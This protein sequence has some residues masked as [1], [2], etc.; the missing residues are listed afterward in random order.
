MS[1]NGSTATDVSGA[2]DR[3]TSEDC[4]GSRSVESHVLSARAKIR[5]T[6]STAAA[7]ASAGFRQRDDALPA[8][9]VEGA[10][11]AIWLACPLRT[12]SMSAG[13]I[14]LTGPPEASSQ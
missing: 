8:M 9:T 7:E 4:C 11:R 12:D 6:A 2:A 13:R 10:S 14:L 3:A 5:P 1:I